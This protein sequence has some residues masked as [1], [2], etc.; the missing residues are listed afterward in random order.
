MLADKDFGLIDAL[1]VSGAGFTVVFLELALLAVLVFLLSKTVRFFLRKAEDKKAAA[2]SHNP[3]V[4]AVPQISAALSKKSHG[5]LELVETDEPTAAIIMAII[6]NKTQ[7]PLNKLR[8]IR[9]RLL[10]E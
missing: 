10:E 7:I 5:Q 4:E 6:S 3:S 9:I 8:F 2:G 1:L